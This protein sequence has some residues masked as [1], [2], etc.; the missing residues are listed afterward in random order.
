MKSVIALKPSTTDNSEELLQE[1][2]NRGMSEVLIVGKNKDLQWEISTSYLNDRYR[3]IG[4][5]QEM[6]HSLLD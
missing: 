6:I 2:I 5:L 4:I 1:A 3:M